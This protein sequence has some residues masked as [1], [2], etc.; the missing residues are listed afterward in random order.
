[1]D[2]VSNPLRIA[3]VAPLWSAIPPHT[4]GGIESLMYSLIE[5]L[6]ERGHEVTLFATGDCHTSA[7]L[8]PVMETSLTERMMRNEASWQE[9]YV[10][11]AV[12]QA[13]ASAHK[14]DVIHFHVGC[15]W[16]P[17]LPLVKTRSL[18]TLHSYLCPD[19]H[20]VIQQYPQVNL[21]AISKAQTQGLRDIPVVY[22]ACDFSAIPFGEPRGDY[23]AFLG[24]MSPQKNP[25]GAIEV[26]RKAGMPI[27]LAGEPQSDKEKVY[28][29]Q[30][31]KPLLKEPGVEYL[32]GANFE[33]KCKLLRGAS[34]LLFP[35]TWPEPFGLVMIEAMACGTPVLALGNGS[36]P[37]LVENGV[38]G[39]YADNLTDL[40]KLL[41]DVLAL[42]RPTIRAAAAKRFD[43]PRMVDD[44]LRLYRN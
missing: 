26:A 2:H 41:P 7:E 30:V 25:A 4:Y 42:D 22:N 34:V 16:I 12:A 38:T 19:D 14:F 9:Y 5:K 27:V 37:E 24:R 29:E 43:I 23:L 40:E 1:M 32:G 11:T 6:T 44:Y 3:Q 31:V 8:R 36:V 18:L 20:W 13:L 35:I 39:Y 28:F 33:Q 15:Q 17:F 10:N 21:A